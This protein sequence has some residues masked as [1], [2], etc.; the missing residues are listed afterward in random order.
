MVS[1][2]VANLSVSESW[3]VGSS[4]TLFAKLLLWWCGMREVD[5]KRVFRKYPFASSQSFF[6]SGHFYPV[7]KQCPK[8]NGANYDEGHINA[9]TGICDNCGFNILA[10]GEEYALKYLGWLWAEVE[11]SLPVLRMGFVTMGLTSVWQISE[12]E[13]QKSFALT[14]VHIGD[15]SRVAK[16]MNLDLYLRIGNCKAEIGN[17][18]KTIYL[19]EAKSP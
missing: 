13:W 1:E 17:V 2:Q 10:M 4:P 8:C 14:E 7:L 12:L 3:L 19:N 9:R 6:V 16:F 18:R 11:R 5:I 15:C